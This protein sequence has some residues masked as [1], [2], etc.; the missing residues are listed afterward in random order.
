MLCGHKIQP[1]FR[2]LKLIIN[3]AKQVRFCSLLLDAKSID[4][5][6]LNSRL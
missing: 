2:L 5:T 3:K 1:F 6:Y 4:F